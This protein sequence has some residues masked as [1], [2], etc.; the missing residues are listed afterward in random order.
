[1]IAVLVALSP[2]A[3]ASQSNALDLNALLSTFKDP[4]WS[5][6]QNPTQIGKRYSGEIKIDAIARDDAKHPVRLISRIFINTPDNGLLH[7]GI[8]AFDINDREKAASLKRGSK[9]RVTGRL[10][11]MYLK[12]GRGWTEFVDATIDDVDLR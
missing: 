6:A 3:I 4:G 2:S 5:L 10:D 7:A 9:V 11:R 8:I 1:M 12:D